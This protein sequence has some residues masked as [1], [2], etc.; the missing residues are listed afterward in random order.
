MRCFG[1]AFSKGVRIIVS[2]LV[3]SNKDPTKVQGAKTPVFHG[4]KRVLARL[5]R[6]PCPARKKTPAGGSIFPPACRYLSWISVC[7]SNHAPWSHYAAG[8][9]PIPERHAGPG[10]PGPRDELRGKLLFHAENASR[11]DGRP[12]APHRH[13]RR[14]GPERSHG[15]HAVDVAKG[16]SHGDPAR[17][18][19]GKARRRGPRQAARRAPRVR[20]PGMGGREP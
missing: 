1:R 20:Q 5:D 2:A 12:V 14:Q 4:K 11:P 17:G 18:G 13:R 15:R 8:S 3:H 10:R 16:D 9:Q 7:I 6:S 19:P